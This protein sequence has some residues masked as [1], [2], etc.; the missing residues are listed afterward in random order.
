M[1]TYNYMADCDMKVFVVED[2]AAVRERLVELIAGLSG[3]EVVGE[4]DAYDSAV[5]GIL[6]TCPDVALL[7]ISLTRGSGIDVLVEVRQSLP[8][9]RGV[10]LTNY[11]TPQHVKAAA[12]AGADFF[13]D[14]S[15]DFERIPEILEQLRDRDG[16]R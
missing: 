6:Q 4:A 7:D 5:H 16:A 15:A 8:A 9:M 3:I 13:L 2:S 11:V 10:V 1:D 12:D 14:K